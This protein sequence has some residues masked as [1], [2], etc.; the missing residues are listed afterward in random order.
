MRPIRTEEDTMDLLR[1]SKALAVISA[2]NGLGLFRVLMDGPK[3]L[4]D[5]D[6]DARALQTTAP[7]LR[8]LGLLV[9]DDE[10][11]GLS[12]TAVALYEQNALPTARNLEFLADQSQLMEILREGGPAKGHDGRSKATEGGVHRDSPEK[13][14]EFLDMLYRRSES[15]ARQTCAW[16]EPLLRPGSRV[17]D[18]GGG[19]GRYARL[20]ADAGHRATLFDLPHVIDYARERHGEAIDYLRGDYHTATDFGGPYDLV[21]LSNI[22][23]SESSDTNQRLMHELAAVTRPGGHIVLKDM[24]LDESEQNPTAAVFFGLTMLLHTREGRAQRIDHARQWLETAGCVDVRVA[25]FGSYSLVRAQ[26]A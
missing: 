1:A 4:L 23:H 6:A 11:V 13:T 17:L 16:I 19:H 25:H 9:G 26:R 3:R 21:L 24:F 5:L 10:R 7:V 12:A 20:F 22:V 15:S 18:L 2:W 8:H 14:R